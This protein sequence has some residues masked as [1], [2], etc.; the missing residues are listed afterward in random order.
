MSKIPVSKGYLT[1]IIMALINSIPALATFFIVRSITND[2]IMSIVISSIVFII[3]IGFSVKIA[4]NMLR[5][6]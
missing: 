5:K 4:R 6:S 1:S 3:A 2:L